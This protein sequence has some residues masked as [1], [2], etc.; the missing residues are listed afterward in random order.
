MRSPTTQVVRR[1]TTRSADGAVRRSGANPRN[2]PR[3]MVGAAV[4]RVL[5]PRAV[6]GTGEADIPLRPALPRVSLRG[7][8]AH[9]RRVLLAWTMPSQRADGLRCSANG[10]VQPGG[11]V[12]PGAAFPSWGA[13]V[14]AK[15][16]FGAIASVISLLQTSSSFSPSWRVTGRALAGR[17]YKVGQTVHDR[18]SAYLP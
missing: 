11:C 12:A 16:S 5:S 15:L 18:A 17:A 4:S 10:R 8:V 1:R 3:Q 14:C 2:D 7:G 13:M 6:A 9:S